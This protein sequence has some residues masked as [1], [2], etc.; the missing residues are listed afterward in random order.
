MIRIAAV[1]DVHYSE[2]SRGRLCPHWE[3]VHERADVFLLAGDLTGHGELRQAEVLVDDLACVKVPIVAVL[4]NHEYHLDQEK[5]IRRRLESAGVVVLEGEAT[6]LDVNG[7][8]L[9]IAG[10]KGFGGGFVGA[11]IHNFGEPEMKAYASHTEALAQRLAER[12]EGLSAADYRVALLH[13]SPAEATLEGER[14]EIW[15]FLGSFLLAEAIDRAGADLALHGHAHAGSEK[16]AT[17]GG[18]P[19]RNV[20][21]PVIKQPFALYQLGRN[22]T[23]DATS[24][25]E[26]AIAVER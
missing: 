20:A 25:L 4:G 17:P 9:G 12:L 23:T 18:V 24:E 14:R 6:T 1:G 19:V 22:A 16:G 2:D 7:Q 21:F 8:T 13:Y 15:P 11:C 5:E 10:T 3:R 26:A